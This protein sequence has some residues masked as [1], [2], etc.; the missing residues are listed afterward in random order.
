MAATLRLQK[1]LKLLLKSPEPGIV[2]KP[3]SSTNILDWYFLIDGPKDTAYD[4][5]KY[6]GKILFPQDY[7]FTP[8]GIS[9]S[10][11]SG[12]FD[13]GT[14]ICLSTAEY[15]PETWTPRWSVASLF[16]GDESAREEHVRTAGS[17]RTS[18]QEKKKLAKESV[19]WLVRNAQF[20]KVFA[21][22]IDAMEEEER[23]RKEEN[24][25]TNE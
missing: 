9:M 2:A 14:K 20:R 18:E 22:L 17:I 25:E 12:R 15:H 24:N 1:E 7:P 5:G 16:A 10:T 19:A 8:P 6:L 23:K 11:P 3:S 13:P 4:K 21:E